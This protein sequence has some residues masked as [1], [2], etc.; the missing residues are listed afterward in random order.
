LVAECDGE[1]IGLT[2]GRIEASE[3][4]VANLYQV[5]VDPNYRQRG[6]GQM[7]LE[8]SIAWA[9]AKNAR[10]LDL[11]VTFAD[12]PA[13]RLNRRNERVNKV[14]AG[15]TGG[16]LDPFFLRVSSPLFCQNLT[17]CLLLSL[18]LT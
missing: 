12:S 15:A 1:P 10:Y 11:G 17:F 9:R 16:L 3:P 2:W 5:W 13:L 7:L 6:V 14:A 4:E 8:R 18:C